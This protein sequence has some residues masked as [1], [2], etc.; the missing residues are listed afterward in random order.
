VQKLFT[1]YGNKK[2][3]FH[4]LVGYKK[5]NPSEGRYLKTRCYLRLKQGDPMKFASI[6]LKVKLLTISFLLAVPVSAYA[7]DYYLYTYKDPPEGGGCTEYHYRYKNKT[8]ACGGNFWESNFTGT[9]WLA[10]S[11]CK[12]LEEIYGKQWFIDRGWVTHWKVVGSSQWIP[13]PSFT[14]EYLGAEE[15]SYYGPGTCEWQAVVPELPDNPQPSPPSNVGCGGKT[16]C[17]GDPVD[18]FNR[19]FTYSENDIGYPSPS[20]VSLT[21]NYNSGNTTIGL[22]G[23]GTR[24][25]YDHSL[26]THGS[27]LLYVTPEGGRYFLSQQSNG[28]YTNTMYPFLKHAKVRPD[29][30]QK[31][32]LAGGAAYTFDSNGRL[33]EG[34]DANGNF[35]TITRDPVSGAITG[36]DDTFGRNLSITTTTR[37]VGG[38]PYTLIDSVSDVLGRTVQYEYDA[39]ALLTSVTYPDNSQ[40][41]YTYENGRVKSINKIEDINNPVEVIQVENNYDPSTGLVTSQVH[42]LD[43]G[44]FTISSPS[45]L[46]TDVTDPRDN[47]VTYKFNSHG[48][49]TETID[50]YSRVTLYDKTIETYHG[51]PGTNELSALT[52]TVSGIVRTTSYTYENGNIKTVTDPAGNVTTYYYEDS[53]NPTKPTRIAKSVSGQPDVET[54]FEHDASGN[55]AKVWLPGAV[56]PTMLTRTPTGLV[57]SVVSAEGDETLFDYYSTGLIA[58]SVD[59][60]GNLTHYEYDAIG[61][62]ASVTD[63]R[64]KVT[65]YV[66]DTTAKEVEITDPLG[67]TTTIKYDS[68]GDIIWLTDARGNTVSYTY[69]DRGRAESMTDQVLA[70]ESYTHDASDNLTSIT[71]RKSQVTSYSDYDALDRLTRSDYQDGSYTTLAYDDLGRIVSTVDSISGMI[72]YTYTDTSQGEFPDKVKQVV[73]PG[74]TVSYSYDDLGRRETMDVDG[75]LTVAYQYLPNGLVDTISAT[76]PVTGAPMV[77]SFSYDNAGRR[78]GIIY[79][80]GTTTSYTYDEAGRLLTV[81]H[82]DSTEQVLESL[83]YSYDATG[84]RTSMERPGINP[85]LPG[86]SNSPDYDPANRLN[87]FNGD[88]LSYDPN[89]NVTGW[90]DMFFT[91]DAR[92]RLVGITNAPAGDAS[93]SYDSSGRRIEKTVGGV[94]TKYLYD[95]LDIVKEMDG[96]G[97]TKA[98]YVRTLNIDEPFARIAA[99]GTVRYYHADALGSIIALT[100]TNG[101]IRT[102]YNYSPFGVTQLMGE[103]SDNPFQYTGREYDGTGLYYYRARYYSP[104]MGRFISEDPIGLTGGIN[105][106][107]YV[108]NRPVNFVD[109]LGLLDVNCWP[110]VGGTKGGKKDGWYGHVSITLD[111]GTYISYWPDRP[112]DDVFD[113]TAPRMPNYEAD[114]AGEGGRMPIKIHIEGLDEY[115]IDNWWMEIDH[116]DFSTFNNCSDITA[117]AL[118]HGGFKMPWHPIYHPEQIYTDI[119]EELSRRNR[120]Q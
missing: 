94:T 42:P 11:T 108:G 54:T 75:E 2:L 64:Q 118:W 40:I 62:L 56:A 71:D 81:I 79:P 68:D 16:L 104:E 22:F 13:A 82:K 46:R 36:I 80:N 97:N 28:N 6:L 39:D 41:I 73:S 8:D 111:N 5:R 69:D 87:A 95:G 106:Y 102:Q 105:M 50:P 14:I 113:S 24:S 37:T 9:I 47:T 120:A 27:Q 67:G 10:T 51:A 34:T 7:V 26:S 3:D 19:M 43:G 74:G 76:N 99:D 119:L 115:A 57:K 107:A 61:R 20:M 112:L 29:N 21:R 18:P 32:I 109:P 60:L 117:E 66:Y 86:P 90:G 114:I 17:V 52:E 78:T 25:N 44:T 31:L 96:L 93:F 15:I 12:R 72:E 35:V 89:G 55:L 65:Y 59:P 85:L 23:K 33:I 48:Y 63:P 70:T 58:N 100:D 4:S 45:Y 91:W 110:P 103:A 84:N 101:D 30:M 88:P 53:N 38:T 83:S 92:D 1:I 98:W 49:L 116:G 77:F